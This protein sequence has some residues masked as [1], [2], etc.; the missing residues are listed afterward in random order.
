M[1]D[2]TVLRVDVD[3]GPA[4]RVLRKV[5]GVSVGD[6]HEESAAEEEVPLQDESQRPS[7]GETP[8]PSEPD[9]DE[10]FDPDDQGDGGLTDRLPP[11]VREWGLLVVGVLFLLV[12]VASGALWW[13]R[14]RN[15][16][17]EASADGLSAVDRFDEPVD[18][19]RPERDADDTSIVELGGE[20]THESA[21]DGSTVDVV[22]TTED[23]GPEEETTPLDPTPSGVGAEE[24]IESPLEA[25]AGEDRA[26][27]DTEGEDED[28]TAT[29]PTSRA[30]Q[31][32]GSVDVAPLLGLSFLAVG[33]AVVRWAQ[34]ESADER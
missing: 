9:V 1:R 11:V 29:T 24:A 6:D 7:P 15:A 23:P 4:T 28:E 21:D 19:W 34:R 8:P 26:E 2:Y 20:T 27:D 32:A 13:L 18:E 14:R 12:G 25:T 16:G 3:F 31:E 33:A 30:D 10:P 17:S 22:R 5:P